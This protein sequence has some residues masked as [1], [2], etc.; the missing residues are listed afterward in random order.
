MFFVQMIGASLLKECLLPQLRL[1]RPCWTRKGGSRMFCVSR[2]VQRLVPG[3]LQGAL[4]MLMGC[5]LMEGENIWLLNKN[6]LGVQN[7][8]RYLYM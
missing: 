1:W 7:Y 4:K 8:L 3:Q 6:G 5:V 2:A